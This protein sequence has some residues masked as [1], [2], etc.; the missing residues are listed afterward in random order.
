M[1]T[2]FSAFVSA[3]EAAERA[4][5]HS[6]SFCA[7]K[8]PTAHMQQP[9]YASGSKNAMMWWLETARIAGCSRRTVLGF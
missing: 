2:F 3:L 4:S 9:D 6:N 5:R 1:H 7:P 8:S